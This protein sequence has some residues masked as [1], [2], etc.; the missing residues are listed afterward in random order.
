MSFT[1]SKFRKLCAQFLNVIS[2]SH[3][4]FSLF[5]CSAEPFEVKCCNDLPMLPLPLHLIFTYLESCGACSSLFYSLLSVWIPCFWMPIVCFLLSYL[6]VQVCSW[7]RNNS[8]GNCFHRLSDFCLQ[9]ILFLIYSLLFVSV[10]GFWM[11]IL[12]F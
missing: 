3:D 4:L 10:R 11:P 1:G 9:F 8:N 12:C 6:D 7:C 5:S 2:I